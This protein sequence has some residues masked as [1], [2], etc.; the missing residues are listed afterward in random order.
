MEQRYIVAYTVKHGGKYLSR[1]CVFDNIE[2]ART[3][4]KDLLELDSLY[5]ASISKAIEGTD[6]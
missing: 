3:E 4:Y 1:Y 5:T 2:D 6:I